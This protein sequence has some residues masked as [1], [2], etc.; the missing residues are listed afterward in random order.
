MVG[1]GTNYLPPTP[2]RVGLVSE[3]QH[4]HESSRSGEFELDPSGDNAGHC[5]IYC[6][7]DADP[8]CKSLSESD[9]DSGQEI[10]MVGQGE[11]SANQTKEEIA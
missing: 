3:A 7:V 9:S 11:P 10:F 2:D 6:L 4:G 8:I 1:L 5:N